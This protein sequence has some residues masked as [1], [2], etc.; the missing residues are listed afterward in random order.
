[1]YVV[2]AVTSMTPQQE[3]QTVASPPEQPSKTFP[4]TGKD[5]FEPED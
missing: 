3:I 5:D 2:F 1:M 4:T